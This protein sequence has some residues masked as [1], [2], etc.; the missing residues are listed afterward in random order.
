MLISMDV[1]RNVGENKSVKIQSNSTS[2]SNVI[3]FKSQQT[4]ESE[5]RQKAIEAI[6]KRSQQLHW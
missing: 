4:L 5:S 6:R 1:E 3:N 2:R